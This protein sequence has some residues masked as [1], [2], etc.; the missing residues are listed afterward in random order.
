MQQIDGGYGGGQLLRWA[1]AMAAIRTVPIEV[2]NIRGARDNPGMRP[3]H[4]TAVNAA[5]AFTDAEVSGLSVGSEQITFEPQTV[6][7]GSAA[8]DVG[9]AGSIALVFDTVLPLG[10][11]APEPITLTATGGTDVKWSPPLEY[12]RSV[13]LPFLADFGFDATIDV[14]KRGFYP[15]GGGRATLE[16]EPSAMEPIGGTERG[17]LEELHVASIA[18]DDLSGADVAERQTAA[19]E[20]ALDADTDVPVTT[21]TEYVDALSTGTSIVITAVYEGARAGFSALGEPGK[22]AEDVAGDAVSDFVAF[23]E[24]G[25]AVE[26]NLAD[27]ILP[28]LAVSGGAIS[29]PEVTSHIETATRL[30]GEFGYE[31]QID[32][33]PAGPVELRVDYTQ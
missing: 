25:G 28:F 5:A 6:A 20:A 21:T 22:P 3:Q 2:S 18:T 30:L 10:L 33:T 12:H 8:V 29:T 1:V 17:L 14:H 11:E 23:H 15:R 24:T 16:I 26:R 19:A 27:Q 9:T 4:I 7:G 31:I 32:E 13:K